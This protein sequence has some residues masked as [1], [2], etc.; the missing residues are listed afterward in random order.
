M[1]TLLGAALLYTL[2][3]VAVG[4]T[5]SGPGRGGKGA[6]GTLG[7]HPHSERWQVMYGLVAD[8]VWFV[9]GRQPRRGYQTVTSISEVKQDRGSSRERHKE[10]K[11]KKSGKHD[12]K[13]K[14]KRSKEAR[15]ALLRS[16]VLIRF[17][18]P[19]SWE[20]ENVF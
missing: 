11:E 7:M 5:Q 13:K 9:F 10:K 1:I 20:L 4:H 12:T 15:L 14:Q 2:G 8:G 17:L 3:G 6:L 16:W 18:A 19:P